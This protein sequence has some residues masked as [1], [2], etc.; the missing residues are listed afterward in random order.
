MTPSRAAVALIALVGLLAGCTAQ[1]APEPT[2][3]DAARLQACADAAGTIVTAAGDLVAE[4]ELPSLEASAAP[5]PGPTSAPEPLP[6]SSGDAIADAVTAAR[7]TRDELGCDPGAFTADLEAGLAEIEPDSPIAAAVWRRV[8]ASVLG[9]VEQE[10]REWAMTADEDLIEVLARAADG[11]TVVLPAGTVEID[12]TL[13]LLAGVTLRGAGAGETVVSSSAPDAAIMVVTDGLVRL[14][15]LTLQLAPAVPA[16]GIVAGPSAS[17]ALDA[18]RVTGAASEG[19]GDSAGGAGVYLSAQGSEGSGRGTTLEI[20]ASTFDANAWAG[21]AVTGGHRVSIESSTFRGNGG[22][23]IVF[24]DETSGS[25]ASSTFAGNPV[26]LA[27]AGT[28]TPAVIGSTFTGGT[29]GL[30]ADAAAAPSIERATIS[31]ASSAAVIFGGDSGGSIDATVCR[32]VP[33]GIVIG[34]GAAPTLGEND[35]SIGR[36]TG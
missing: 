20:T 30:Q 27:A 19:S 11:T 28:S 16:S 9:T 33:H 3:T 2:N 25:V 32:D 34:D 7:A 4:Y 10:A 24:L 35:C 26:G 1:P 23:G 36:G 29:V 18:V 31:G 8:S 5:T 13:V 22:A 17:L 15:A 21:L 6:T 14:E 12:Q